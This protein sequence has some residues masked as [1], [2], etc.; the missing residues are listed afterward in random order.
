VGQQKNRGNHDTNVKDKKEY[1][2]GWPG[3][4]P[5]GSK[6]KEPE[7]NRPQ[8]AL[9]SVENVFGV[10]NPVHLPTEAPDIPDHTHYQANEE[11]E[12]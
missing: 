8:G 10:S 12:K 7:K 4:P 1:G 6:G 9:N 2:H 3:L 11:D 5:S